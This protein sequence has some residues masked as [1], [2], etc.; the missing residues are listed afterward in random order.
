MFSFYSNDISAEPVTIGGSKYIFPSDRVALLR[1]Y[2]TAFYKLISYWSKATYVE[3]QEL[4]KSRQMN[5]ISLETKNEHGKVIDFMA[6][7]G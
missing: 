5:L 1:L 3:A 6:E 7:L 4:C 2:C